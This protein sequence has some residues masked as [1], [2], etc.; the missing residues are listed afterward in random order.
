MN[1]DRTTRNPSY[2]LPRINLRENISDVDNDLREL[3]VNRWRQKVNNR[4]E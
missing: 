3:K 4:E 1:S 2:L